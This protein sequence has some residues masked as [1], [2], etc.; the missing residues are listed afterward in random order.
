MI[1]IAL[2]TIALHTLT[3]VATEPHLVFSCFPNPESESPHSAARQHGRV[4]HSNALFPHTKCYHHSPRT[5]DSLASTFQALRLQLCT[6]IPRQKM[7]MCVCSMCMCA[8]LCV[9]V[10]S[11]RHLHATVHMCESE[12]DLRCQ[13]L[14]SPLLRQGLLFTAVCARLSAWVLL[15]SLPFSPPSSP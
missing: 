13:S 1:Y 10:C 5:H 14:P 11:Y 6:T 15:E 8:C 3:N 2:S 4:C 12:E 9:C 7:F